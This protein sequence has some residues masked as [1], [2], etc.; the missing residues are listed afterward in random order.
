[1]KGWKFH[2]Y[3][4]PI[5]HKSNDSLEL[6]LNIFL[7]DVLI[8][9]NIL[10]KELENGKKIIIIDTNLNNIINVN[11][12]HFYKH[13]FLTNNKFKQRLIDYY[14]QFD[15]YVNGPREILKKDN[16]DIFVSTGK[17]QIEF[18]KIYFN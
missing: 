14:N 15:V 16:N 6:A 10:L 2:T 13:L 5:T 1:M 18:S 8:D 7:K 17:W 3:I 12:I 9:K 4:K 11:G